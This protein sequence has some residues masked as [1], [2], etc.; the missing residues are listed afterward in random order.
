M[1]P[2]CCLMSLI[3]RTEICNM[4]FS[5]LN[6]VRVVFYLRFLPFWEICI[7]HITDV[8]VI[9]HCALLVE[10]C[11]CSCHLSCALEG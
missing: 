4:A 1:S 2:L 10:T 8:A 6:I 11:P 7:Q 9:C 5:C 3:L